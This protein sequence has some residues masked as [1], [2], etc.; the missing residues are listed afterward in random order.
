MSI[1]VMC[2]CC[3]TQ[4]PLEAG[5]IEDD[6]KRLAKLCAD[7]EPAVARAALGYLRLFKPAKQALRVSRAVLIL[8]DLSTLIHSGRISK[9]DRSG[10]YRPALAAH[11]IAGM[12]QM[13]APGLRLELPLKNHNYLRAIVY[14]LADVADAK[15][16]QQR[17]KDARQRRSGDTLAKVDKRMEH[18]LWARSMR[19]RGMMDEAQY[20]AEL[21]RADGLNGN[22]DNT[23]S[24]NPTET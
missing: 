6:A 2:P 22:S 17:D 23:L 4:F 16:E 18:I 14:G 8:T 12:E 11:W 20:Q 15:A 21:R 5:L 9:D 7:L 10:L 3:A 1:H 19:D 13:L 24:V